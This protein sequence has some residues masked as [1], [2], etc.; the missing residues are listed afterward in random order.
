M[1]STS[2]SPGNAAKVSQAQKALLTRLA[3]GD[4]FELVPAGYPSAGPDASRWW[5]TA[6][7]LMRL[8]MVRRMGDG[9]CL[10]DAGRQAL[11]GRAS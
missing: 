11:A 10:T 3:A 5:R 1:T 9:V 7:C 2:A 6:H 8:G 4:G